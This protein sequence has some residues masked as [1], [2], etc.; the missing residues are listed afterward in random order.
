MDKMKIIIAVSIILL[1]ISNSALL[2]VRAE[3][4]KALDQCIPDV[5]QKCHHIF[6]YA[7]ELEK[8]N[9]RLNK[10]FSACDPFSNPGGTENE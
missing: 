8:E 9:A 1:L 2:L 6:S 4:K 10:L 5:T 7:S 3:E